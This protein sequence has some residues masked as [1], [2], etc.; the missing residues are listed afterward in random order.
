MSPSTPSYFQSHE[1]TPRAG[2]EF[3]SG[4]KFAFGGRRRRTH[5]PPLTMSSL[6]PHPLF[7]PSTASFLIL[8]HSFTRCPCS[9]VSPLIDDALPPSLPPSSLLHSASFLIP[10]LH[11]FAGYPCSLLSPVLSTLIDDACSVLPHPFSPPLRALPQRPSSSFSTSL[12]DVLAVF[13]H[14]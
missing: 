6:P 3:V 4:D 12:L 1:L 13:S 2:A 8:L 14:P 11:S 10:V 7:A 5:A 9:L